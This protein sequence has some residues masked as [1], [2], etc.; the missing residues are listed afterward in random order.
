MRRI[1]RYLPL[2]SL[3]GF[4]LPLAQAQSEFNIAVG[5][6]SAQSKATNTG[7]EGDPNSPN[8]FG[9]CSTG[10]SAT[11]AS[12]S[13]LKSFMMG[14]RGDLMLWKH[15]GVGADVT[16]QPAK[17]N[18]VTYSPAVINA[19]GYN[20]QSRTTFYDFDGMVQPLRTPKVA[21]QL[22]GGI[23]GA[24]LKFYANSTSTNAVIGSQTYSQY[25]GSSNHFQ[26]HGGVGV[27][28]FVKGSLFIRPQFDVHYVHN[29]TQ[30][31]SNVVTEE[32]V[33]VGY[34]WGSH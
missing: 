17:Q 1:F 27:N 23:G 3:L 19:G 18:Y 16:F 6:G 9:P 4:M 21:L 20:L 26:V 13:A 15:F 24:N 12:P 11:C 5:F 34:N 10:S 29:L 22:L 8:F 14:F 7:V 30:F 31:G 33:W 2:V 25:F 28:I 32:T